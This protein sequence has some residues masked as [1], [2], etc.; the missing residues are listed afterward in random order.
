[1]NDDE[2]DPER[3]PLLESW[4][5]ALLPPE[6]FA[7]SRAALEQRLLIHLV[8]QAFDA[9]RLLTDE[10]GRE[11]FFHRDLRDAAAGAAD[12]A[13]ADALDAVGRAHFNQTIIA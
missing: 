5:P 8:P 10:L 13:K 3:E 2:R 11:Q 7:K 12:V 1:M 6:E 9:Q 4:K